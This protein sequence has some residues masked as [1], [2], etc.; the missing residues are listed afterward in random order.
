M[1]G[2]VVFGLLVA[3]G[4][5]NLAIYLLVSAPPRLDEATQVDKSGSVPVERVL[6]VLQSENDAA[7]LLWTSEIVGAGAR[8]GLSFDETWQD[9]DVEAGPLPALF[10]RMVAEN[11]IRANTNV[12][13]FLGAETPLNE[14]NRFSGAQ[15]EAFQKLKA[16][17]QPQFFFDAATERHVGMFPDVAV[18]DA[19]VQCHNS[20]KKAQKTTWRLRDVM[21]ATTWMIPKADLSREQTL[22]L[23]KAFRA[24]VRQGYTTYLEKTKSFRQPPEIGERWPRQ[25]RHLPNVDV[26]MGELVL[27]SSAVTLRLLMD[28]KGAIATPEHPVTPMASGGRDNGEPR[29]VVR[30]PVQTFLELEDSASRSPVKVDL[31]PGATFTVVLSPGARMR[32]GSP[33]KVTV[34]FASKK[35]NLKD[36][37]RRTDGTVDVRLVE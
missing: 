13:L 8:T 31:P 16:T 5:L 26:F 36:L 17:R 35:L 30:T 19:C 21:G 20:H 24:A 9:R 28:D 12:N 22:E 2:A 6:E 1:Q 25:G 29:L 4:L 14:A 15:L 7:R 34:D 33:D 10:L 32:V 11:L 18:T 37:P 3:F 23:V 27:R